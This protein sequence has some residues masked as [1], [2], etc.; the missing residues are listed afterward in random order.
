MIQLCAEK[1]SNQ[2]RIHHFIGNHYLSSLIQR[3]SVNSPLR[4]HGHYKQANSPEPIMSNIF[5]NYQIETELCYPNSGGGGGGAGQR[6]IE[7]KGTD[8]YN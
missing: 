1:A 6:S 5:L 7:L 4:F 2:I 3:L 8:G